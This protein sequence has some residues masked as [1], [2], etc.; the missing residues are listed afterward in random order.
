[1][2]KYLIALVLVISLTLCSAIGL[3]ERSNAEALQQILELLSENPAIVHL[4]L[5][6]LENSTDVG[7]NANLENDSS[8]NITTEQMMYD[9]QKSNVDV[10]YCG[11]FVYFNE[12]TVFYTFEITKTLS[13]DTIVD[14]Y[15]SVSGTSYYD[16]NNT[17]RANW[18]RYNDFEGPILMRYEKFNEGW[19]LTKVQ[20]QDG[21]LR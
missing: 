3:A 9:L 13:K 6:S 5:D 4:F 14:Y 12:N 11:R 10:F 19:A 7:A 8:H 17:S 1:M 15:V 20:T 18:Y 2:K 21:W 16:A